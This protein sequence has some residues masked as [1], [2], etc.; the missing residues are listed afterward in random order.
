M[1]K[2]IWPADGSADR[3]QA[4]ED[5]VARHARAAGL[6]MKRYA[7]DLAG[8]CEAWLTDTDRTLRRFGTTGTPSFWINGRFIQGASVDAMAEMIDAE[9]ARVKASGIAPAKYYEQV[10]VGQGATEA[11][12]ISPFD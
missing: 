8:P 6:D 9:L 4:A 1:W 11:V 12:M 5:A 7:A 10:V 3:E 2:A